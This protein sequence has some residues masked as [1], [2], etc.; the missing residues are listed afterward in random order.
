MKTVLVV[1]DSPM[2]R[3]LI[4]SVLKA[5]GIRVILAED[6]EEGIAAYKKNDVD[7]SIID[8]FLPKKGGLQ[9]MSEMVNMGRSPKF[10]A[11][12]G[13]EAFNPEAIVELAKVYDVVDT[14]TKPI[15][16]RKLVETV[17]H[18]LLLD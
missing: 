17:R 8:I 7:L 14:F 13:G 12:S 18:A 2:I 4:Q 15:N 10:I 9:V 5:E 16:A 1:D 6:G 11:I 3:E